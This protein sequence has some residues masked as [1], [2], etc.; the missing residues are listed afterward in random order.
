MNRRPAVSLVIFFLAIVVGCS[1]PEPLKPYSTALTPTS[2][3]PDSQ[4]PISNTATPPDLAETE[5]IQVPI[6]ETATLQSVVLSTDTPEPVESTRTFTPTAIPCNQAAPGKPSIDQ[7]IPDGT[8]LKPGESFSKTWRLVNTGSCPWTQK[9]AAVWFSG[10]VVSQ[11]RVQNFNST[12]PSGGQVDVTVDMVAPMKPGSHQSNWKLR[13][14]DG[15]L[16]GLGPLGDAPFWVQII[17]DEIPVTSTPGIPTEVPA[18]LI[19][20][21]GTFVLP[22]ESFVNFDNGKVENN[23]QSDFVL[24]K[25]AEGAL[26]APVNGST[27]ILF[28]LKT[29]T[30]AECR[31][32]TLNSS[33]VLVQAATDEINICYRTNAGF[34]G[35]VQLSGLA[36]TSLTIT[37]ITWGNP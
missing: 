21:K 13:A 11:V 17:V 14:T 19:K 16:F 37:F 9:Y 22:F 7:T 26:F 31:E 18:P 29:P 6:S 23:A 35:T 2:D 1:L 30:E 32:A 20:I 36:E 8:H 25:D 28:G 27:L 12:I 10:E 3:I 5:I 4:I 34:F 15:T 33:P 24:K